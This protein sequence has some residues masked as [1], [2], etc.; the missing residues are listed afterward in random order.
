VSEPQ[1]AAFNQR[2]ARVLYAALVTSLLVVTL[3]LL[4]LGLRP[5]ALEPATEGLRLVLRGAVLAVLVAG[6]LTVRVVRSGLKPRRIG[7][8]PDEWWAANGERAVV[9]WGLAEGIGIFGAVV[10]VVSGDLL[11]LLAPFVL[12]FILLLTSGPQRLTGN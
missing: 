12:A 5:E 3:V 10:Y 6:A 8:D 7:S 2:V 1:A 11:V 4:V 9:V